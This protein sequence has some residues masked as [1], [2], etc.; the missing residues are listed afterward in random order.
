MRT[1]LLYSQSVKSMGGLDLQMASEVEVVLW[2]RALNLWCMT[3]SLSRTKGLKIDPLLYPTLD[4]W[5][6]N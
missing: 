3:L 4:S 6:Q 1:P 5:C 2:D